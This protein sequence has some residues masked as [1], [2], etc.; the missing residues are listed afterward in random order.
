MIL[1]P[2]SITEREI[3]LHIYPYL[4]VFCTLSC[5]CCVRGMPLPLPRA[6]LIC[7]I[8]FLGLM[9]NTLRSILCLSNT[10]DF[11]FF[12]LWLLIENGA[13]AGRRSA[14]TQGLGRITNHILETK[15]LQYYLLSA[16]QI[17]LLFNDTP[18]HYTRWVLWELSSD[19]PTSML[20][21]KYYTKICVFISKIV[22]HLRMKMVLATTF[23]SHSRQA[24]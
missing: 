20:F 10:I 21:S 19:H 15:G 1:L 2:V 9:K 12:M 14:H 5:P 23:L 3:L 4:H 16:P 6:D 17:L 8:H 18:I 7:P 13:G 24:M 11:S 22:S